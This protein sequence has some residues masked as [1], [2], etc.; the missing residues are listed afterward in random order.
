MITRRNCL[1]II[2]LLLMVTFP[3]WKVPL[4]SFLAPRGGFDPEFDERTRV[5][6][7]FSMNNVNIL[8]SEQGEKTADIRAER[9][10]TSKLPGEYILKNVDADLIT[11][12]GKLINIQAVRGLYTEYDRRL[13]LHRNVVVNSKTDNYTLKT[14]LLLYSDIKKMVNCPKKT[15]FTGDGITIKGS[16]FHWDIN[17][18]F[19]VVGGRVRCTIKG[20]D[21]P[22]PNNSQSQ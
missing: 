6:Q 17:K 10:L 11:D 22:Q 14:N 20:Y 15:V 2:P 1:W 5:E 19:Y 9:V 4:G 12:E 3:L 21:P 7:N 13:K 8:Q 18:G 16:S